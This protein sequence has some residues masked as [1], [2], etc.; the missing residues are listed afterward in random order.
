MVFFEWREKY[1]R[2]DRYE[3]FSVAPRNRMDRKGRC[4]RHESSVPAR[5]LHAIIVLSWHVGR[6]EE[7]EKFH[8]LILG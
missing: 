7:E 1:A 5:A 8:Y 4:T 2:L 3:F 6:V